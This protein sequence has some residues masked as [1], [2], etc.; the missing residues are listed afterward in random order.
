MSSVTDPFLD[1]IGPH[2]RAVQQALVARY[3]ID[4][5]QEVNAEV[6]AWAWE[7]QAQVTQARN[8]AGLLFRVGQSKARR[9]LRWRRDGWDLDRSAAE[10]VLPDVDLQRALR[11]L[12][13]KHRTAVLLVHGFGFTYQAAADLLGASEP[14]LR[15]Q[16]HRAMRRLRE[17][18]DEEARDE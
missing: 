8:P 14:T 9:H 2:W 17:L 4:I 12:S 18:L 7:H 13:P 11:S 15:N 10:Q 3:G 16:L 1:V 6:V 5:G